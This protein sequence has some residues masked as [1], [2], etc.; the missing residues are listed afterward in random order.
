[1][2]RRRKHLNSESTPF[3]KKYLPAISRALVEGENRDRFVEFLKSHEKQGLYALYKK[4]G[5]LY[6]WPS[7]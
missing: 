3:V 7:F 1:M 4:N 2:K 6:Y 5:D